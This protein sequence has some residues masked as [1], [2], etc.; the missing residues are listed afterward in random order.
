[1]SSKDT[2]SKK[3]VDSMRKTKVGANKKAE[4]T[5]PETAVKETAVKAKPAKA[6]KPAQ[7]A[8]AAKS[9]ITSQAANP[10][11]DSYQTRRRIWPD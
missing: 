5:T 8:P 7:K 1:M 11:M 6:A 3:L 10:A 9:S 4:T 2:M